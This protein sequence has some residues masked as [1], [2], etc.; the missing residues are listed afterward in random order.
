MVHW[1]EEGL[2]SVVKLSDIVEPACPQKGSKAKVKWGRSTFPATILEIGSKKDVKKKEKDFHLEKVTES[3]QDVDEG[4]PA[5]RRKTNEGKKAKGKKVSIL[6]VTEPYSPGSTPDE[7]CNTPPP[8]DAALLASPLIPTHGI[9]QDSAA[10][11][12]MKQVLEKVETLQ[13]ALQ[14]VESFVSEQFAA[15]Q[16]LQDVQSAKILELQNKLDNL[17]CTAAAVNT[18]Q[19]FSHLSPATD[20]HQRGV[21][22][23]VTNYSVQSSELQ[24]CNTP[25]RAQS[26]LKPAADVIG[27]N[28]KLLLSVAK[29]GRLAVKLARESYFGVDVM[30]V[31]TVS[32][33]PKDKMK[34]IKARLYEVYRFDNLVEFEPLWQKCL[35]AIGKACQGLRAKDTICIP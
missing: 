18:S 28:S 17:E 23:D 26:Q 6:C 9:Q 21:L 34:E 22:Q 14:G 24:I 7:Q 12:L 32:G 2:T 10:S 3:T 27:A 35:I 33:L 29:A 31:S 13:M 16:V 25:A 4:I 19:Q 1:D 11:D 15:M 20:H 8:A 5:K 30:R